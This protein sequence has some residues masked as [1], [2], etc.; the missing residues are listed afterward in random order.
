VA[1]CRFPAASGS[2]PSMLSRSI[3]PKLAALDSTRGCTCKISGIETLWNR[4][5]VCKPM[6]ADVQRCASGAPYLSRPC[7]FNRA[8]NLAT[9]HGL[10]YGRSRA[11]EQGIACRRRA[12][13][14]ACTPTPTSAC[15]S[16]NYDTAH[17][18]IRIH[19]TSQLES[20]R[21]QGSSR[22]KVARRARSN[23]VAVPTRRSNALAP[24]PRRRTMMNAE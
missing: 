5:A 17:R 22:F 23:G 18:L 14:T 24:C 20:A 1:S 19:L 2:P 15:K 6:S 11:P 4:D 16:I 9:I 7:N 12:S 8:T 13:T 10:L 21:A 3:T